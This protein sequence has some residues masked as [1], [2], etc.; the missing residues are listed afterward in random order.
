MVVVAVVLAQPVRQGLVE[1]VVE[2]VVLG[3]RQP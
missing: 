3:Y 2:M 1:Q